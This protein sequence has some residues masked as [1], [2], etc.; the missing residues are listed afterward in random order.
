MDVL[1]IMAGAAA[2]AGFI[3]VAAV[4]RTLGRP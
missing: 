4:P 3:V 1:W 2:F